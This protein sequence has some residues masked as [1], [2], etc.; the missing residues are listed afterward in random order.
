MATGLK[1]IIFA[2]LTASALLLVNSCNKDN[3]LDCFK[4]TGSIEQQERSIGYFHGLKLYDNINL[5]LIPSANNR[6]VLESG[7]NLMS[8]IETMVNE[9]SILILKNNNSCN[10]VRNYDK[11]IT[12]YLYYSNLR[13]IEYRS[14]GNVTNTDSLKQDSL[15]ID[16]WE[17]AG[18][19]ELLIAVNKLGANIHYGT[20]DMVLGGRANQAYVY[21]L[22]AGR[23]DARACRSEFAYIRNS[24]PNDLY[25]WAIKE[26]NCEI[27]GLGNVYYNGSPSISSWGTGDGK[28]IK[29]E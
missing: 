13:S 23:I 9:D 5:H 2:L 20:A 17:G 22:G 29:L 6:L 8:K 25:V 12:V 14:I 26:L 10:W 27:K 3:V 7:K 28:L 21:Q 4:S 16:V 1:H 15:V 18:K 24:S 19:I 11:P